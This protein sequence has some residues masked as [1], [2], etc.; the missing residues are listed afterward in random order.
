LTALDGLR[1]RYVQWPLRVRHVVGRAAGALPPAWTYGGTFRHWQ[2]LLARA[3]ADPDFG[4]RCRAQ[5]LSRLL[6]VAECRI[7][8]Y[9]RLA[10]EGRER[11]GDD[12]FERLA[13]YPI[14]GKEDVRRAGRDML[15]APVSRLASSCTSGS[16]GRELTV[17]HDP[18]RALADW[19]FVMH[20][21]GS[22]GFR[23]GMVRAGL[24]G[25][26]PPYSQCRP[27]T[28]DPGLREL[29]LS[30]MYLTAS[31]MNGYLAAMREHRVRVLYGYPSALAI[32]AGHCLRSASQ[33]ADSVIAVFASSEET[34]P[35]EQDVIQRAFPAAAVVGHYGLAERVAL[36][37]E[38]PR[39][40]GEYEFE[41]L[42]GH[43]ELVDEAGAPVTHVGET[44]RIVGT[45]YLNHAMPLLRYDTDDV[46][47]L[48]AEA[49][50][51]NGHRLRV[52]NVRSFWERH[53]LVGVDGQL[54]TATAL[55]CHR[56]GRVDDYQLV[57]ERP[58]HAQ[59]LVA[60]TPDA[61]PL[62][63][64]D[65]VREMRTRAAGALDLEARVVAQVPRG[66]R[67]K[68]AVVIQRLD[69]E[70]YRAQPVPTA[71]L[72]R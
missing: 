71:R 43:V 69:V 38:D 17:Y 34:L 57:Q 60:P 48:V 10:H 15:A 31:V 3:A 20:L 24:T 65:F 51:E 1:V 27:W 72:A 26:Q 35:H 21:W 49:R 59:L 68:R 42:Y 7:G 58:G 56:D 67:G 23:P 39:A 5:A 13:Q 19:A 37:V 47:D 50:A 22:V 54:V 41:P 61:P 25:A 46:A 62:A 14:L 6:D 55:C 29:R 12:P 18:R 53:L 64:R 70:E 16:T 40:H 4:A 36:A 30:A 2:A 45:G 52:R 28:Y 33:P 11:P 44:G 66:P 63:W 8:Y 32:L 9:G